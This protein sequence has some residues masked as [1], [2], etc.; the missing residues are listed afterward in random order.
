MLILL[1]LVNPMGLSMT[2]LLTWFAAH[3]V[4][5]SLLEYV[6]VWYGIFSTRHAR[7]FAVVPVSFCS[8]G[9]DQV[10]E[11]GTFTILG[12]YLSIPRSRRVHSAKMVVYRIS[13]KPLQTPMRGARS[14]CLC[15]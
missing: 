12:P 5:L 15:G 10:F 8:F 1:F 11:P 3:R 13:A 7:T 6:C 2:H 14:R 9:H 4:S